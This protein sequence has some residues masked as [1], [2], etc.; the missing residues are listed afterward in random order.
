MATKNNDNPC[1][2]LPGNSVNGWAYY[3]L[4]GI[5]DNRYAPVEKDKII[6]VEFVVTDVFGNKAR[7]KISM[8]KIPMEK[9]KDYILGLEEIS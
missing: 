1:Y 3:W 4:D 5:T 9:A 7:L 8:N 2:L 6:P